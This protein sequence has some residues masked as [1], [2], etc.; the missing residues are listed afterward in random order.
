MAVFSCASSTPDTY[1]MRKTP[2]VWLRQCNGFLLAGIIA[3][4]AVLS[5]NGAIWQWSVPMGDGRAFL[6]IPPHC[7][8]VRAVVVGQDNMIEDGI[9]EHP[10]FRRTLA[11]E[12]IGEVFIAPPFTFIFNFNKGDG[13]K[14]DDM[15][16]RLAA[17][18]GYSELKFAPVV[19]LGHSACASFPWNFAAWDPGRTL[20]VLSV[21]G[22]S[23]ENTLKEDARNKPRF[24]GKS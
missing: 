13:E 24:I 10:D 2:L 19:P 9:L 23:D 3:V 20:A 5:A 16:N 18:S 7:K 1:R 6:W 14:I 22:D 8:Q 11:E 12:N 4:L 17:A 15:M 21:H